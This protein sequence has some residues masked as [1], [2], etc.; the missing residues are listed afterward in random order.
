MATTESKRS[1]LHRRIGRFHRAV[2]EL[3][4][5]RLGHLRRYYFFHVVWAFP[6]ATLLAIASGPHRLLDLWFIATITW[7]SLSWRV[8]AP[9]ARADRDIEPPRRWWPSYRWPVTAALML[10]VT[11]MAI[12]AAP[13]VEAVANALEAPE[14]AFAVE[15][16]VQAALGALILSTAYYFLF[17]YIAALFRITLQW[18]TDR[19]ASGV[20]TPKRSEIRFITGRMTTSKIYLVLLILSFGALSYSYGFF[21]VF[22][23][24]TLPMTFFRSPWKRDVKRSSTAIVPHLQVV[25]LG[26]A[27]L[28]QFIPSDEFIND[29]ALLLLM[30]PLL[31]VFMEPDLATVVIATTIVLYIFFA[32]TALKGN[33]VAI[34]ESRQTSAALS[35]RSDAEVYVDSDGHARTLNNYVRRSTGAV[36]GIT[37]LRGAGK[38]ALLKHIL[39]QFR[40]RYAVVWMTAPVSRQEGF[41]FLMSVCRTICLQAIDD[42]SPV[43]YGR[44]R[45]WQQA[46]GE[47]VRRS[48]GTLSIVIVVFAV[49]WVAGPIGNTFEASLT[50]EQPA[51]PVPGWVRIGDRI[52]PTGYGGRRIA[53]DPVF[54]RVLDAE[55]R[56][57]GNLTR[58]IDTELDA[59]KTPR[60]ASSGRILMSVVPSISPVGFEL[61]RVGS[62]K[63][64]YAN[65]DR[66]LQWLRESVREADYWRGKS[67]RGR[68]MGIRHSQ[69]FNTAFS[70][71]W[72]S[73]QFQDMGPR[74]RK[75]VRLHESYYRYIL[76]GV[77]P[78]I[79]QDQDGKFKP[80]YNFR[81]ANVALQILR[82]HPALDGHLQAEMERL[83]SLL[84]V[85][86]PIVRNQ[87]LAGIVLLA[88]FLEAAEATGA[89]H[90]GNHFLEPGGIRELRGILGRYLK[91]LDKVEA[92][93]PGAV[94]RNDVSE[95][96]FDSNDLWN[97]YGASVVSV[98]PFG[99]ALLI[100]LFGPAI[101]RSGNFIARGVLNW[102]LLALVRASEDF[103]EFLDYSEGREASRGLF[104]RGLSFATKRNL[105]SRTL[106][107]QSLTDRYLV[108]VRSLRDHYNGKVI[109]VIDELDKVSDSEHVRDILLELKGALFEDG[110]YYLISISEDAA[111]AFQGRFTEGR[112]IFESSFDDIV[113][114]D[115]IGTETAHRMVSRRLATDRSLPEMDG[116]AIDVLTMFSGGIPR[117]IVRHLR[118]SV[119]ANGTPTAF[120]SREVGVDV[121]RS[122]ANKLLNEVVETPVGGGELEKLESNCARMVD[123]LDNVSDD[124]PWPP[125]MSRLLEDN[126]AILDPGNLRRELDLASRRETLADIEAGRSTDGDGDRLGK[127]RTQARR[128]AG[129]QACIRLKVMNTVMRHV[130]TGTKAQWRPFVPDVIRCLRLVM[131]QPSLAE[132]QL[133][134]IDERL[135]ASRRKPAATE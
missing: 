85:T 2:W 87:E 98:W 38:T 42:V 116:A 37:G 13:R 8:P 47:L 69:E 132:V 124:E 61:M 112:D 70:D 3:H 56:V 51:S 101:W 29:V 78:P 55:R 26:A 123:M 72:G 11:L 108:Y 79:V 133:T 35:I 31:S 46:L 24:F 102:K 6:V 66:R 15:L 120:G 126:L 62:R 115:S 93:E 128:M 114:V 40:N 52:V 33:I 131:R 90:E 135:G 39:A 4:L 89:D 53:V 16:L 75:F 95:A 30:E 96:A 57:I 109:V 134:R 110:C 122:E 76:R 94:F 25:T 81:M 36:V 1:P 91:L 50:G 22:L 48:A 107:L 17:G 103:L 106:T 82:G 111:R 65:A 60:S 113:E 7:L 32:V 83:R 27:A 34:Q 64:G 130:W 73:H 12:S 49:A 20:H 10:C 100:V 129:V 67:T 105:T 58:E 21:L 18:R 28:S 19:E 9:A 5:R 117:E 121:I 99:L 63:T 104:V 41:A 80:S 45:D 84:G 77:M 119:M 23:P 59:L 88:A 68:L 14:V 74:T 54:S 86:D 118:E 43:L 71:Y 127:L 97:R 125:E 92:D 44:T